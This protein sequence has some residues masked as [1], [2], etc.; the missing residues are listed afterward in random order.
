MKKIAACLL[1]ALLLSG[2]AAEETFETI[3]DELVVEVMAQPREISVQLPDNAVTPV[4][5]GDSAQI[6]LSSDYEILMETLPAGDLNATVQAVSGYGKDRLTI[7][8]TRQDDITRHEFVWACAGEEGDRLGRAVILDDGH[9]HYCM[10]V[11]RDAE[12]K[13]ESQIVWSEVFNS[14]ALK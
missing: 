6:F 14:F 12:T 1:F 3:A 10:S 7:L 13:E 2:C 11:L 9:Y 8:S 4:M 5:D